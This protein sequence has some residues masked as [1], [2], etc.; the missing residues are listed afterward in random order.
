[1][2]TDLAILRRLYRS[3]HIVCNDSIHLFNMS[4][5]MA[6]MCWNCMTD[7]RS[8]SNSRPFPEY[9]GQHLRLV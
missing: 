8:R 3:L 1:M 2:S 9:P 6:F 5:V 7:R 4:S